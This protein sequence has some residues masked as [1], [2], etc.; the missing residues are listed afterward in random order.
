MKILKYIGMA[1]AESIILMLAFF[2]T[3]TITKNFKGNT[4]VWVYIVFGIVML[5]E[6]LYLWFKAKGKYFTVPLSLLFI[7]VI[8]L[9]YFNSPDNVKAIWAVRAVAKN[10]ALPAGIVSLIVSGGLWGFNRIR[11]K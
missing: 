11:I 10:F 6:Y 8:I 5:S 1:A 3:P 4:I 2:L 7:L 9:F